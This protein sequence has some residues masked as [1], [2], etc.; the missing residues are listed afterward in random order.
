VLWQDSISLLPSPEELRLVEPCK[1]LVLSA[2]TA[3]NRGVKAAPEE[4]RATRAEMA[5]TQRDG[6]M[7]P[8][9]AVSCRLTH[10]IIDTLAS[11]AI[12][13]FGEC[14]HLPISALCAYLYSVCNYVCSP[15]TWKL[16]IP[17]A[18]Y[19]ESGVGFAASAPEPESTARPNQQGADGGRDAEREGGSVSYWTHTRAHTHTLS[20]SS[21]L[22]ERERERIHR[23]LILVLRVSQV[24]ES[25]ALLSAR[26]RLEEAF[27]Q[28]DAGKRSDDDYAVYSCSFL[29]TASFETA[30]SLLGTIGGTQGD[31]GGFVEVDR[32]KDV[33][34]SP[35]AP[36]PTVS[37]G[38]HKWSACCRSIL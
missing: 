18:L 27:D 33:H 2:R 17:S 26:C 12:C 28:G 36:V 31:K 1:S 16:I 11:P 37:A 22:R 15:L 21:T 30:R 29:E 35:T 19:G 32:R 7:L 13:L 10:T 23:H 3:N 24:Y 8:F 4:T 25:R 5:S 20:L 9:K 38:W 6:S 14:A 34:L